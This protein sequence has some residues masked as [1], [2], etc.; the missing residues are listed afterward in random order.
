MH[1][2]M[3]TTRKKEIKNGIYNIYDVA[4]VTAKMEWVARVRKGRFN[5]YGTEYEKKTHSQV[6]RIMTMIVSD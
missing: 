2:C 5:N 4:L 1:T 3:S 6:S